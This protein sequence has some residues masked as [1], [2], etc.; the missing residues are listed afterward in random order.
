MVPRAPVATPPWVPRVSVLAGAGDDPARLSEPFGVSRGLDGTVYVTDAGSHHRIR[1]VSPRG[2]V[3]TLAGGIRGFADGTGAAARFD[4]PSGIALHPGGDLIV[5]DTANNAIRR[6]SPTG[7]VTTL[8]GDGVPGYRDGPAA[9]ARFNGPIGVAVDG[10][11]HVFVADTYNDRIREITP[12]GLTLTIAGDGTPGWLDGPALEARFDTPAGL[13]LD[14]SGTLVVADTGNG[15]IRLL[16][17][18]GRVTTMPAGDTRLARPVAVAA[19]A[20]GSVLASDEQ[21]RIF[22][23]S[24]EGTGRLLAGG[25]PGYEGGLGPSARFRRPAG[26]ALVGQRR[27]VL[28]DA[29]NGVLR[30]LTDP[31]RPD[32]RPPPSPLWRAAFDHDAFTRVPLLWPVPPF[33][34]PHEVAGTHGEARGAEGSERFHMGIDV[35]VPQGTA[36]HAVRPGVVSSSVGNGSVGTLNEWMRVGDIVYVHVRAGRERAGHV[37]DTRRYA[38][39]YDADGTL[40]R[41]R[42]KRGARFET[43]DRIGSVNAFNHVHLGVGWA[44]DDHNPLGMRLLHFTDTIP[45]TIAAGGVSLRREDGAPLTVRGAGRTLVSG[46]VEIVVDAWDQADGNVPWRRLGLHTLGYQVLSLDGTP[47]PGFEHPR[48]TLRFDRIGLAADPR[49]VYAAGS[50]IPAYGNRRTR[51]LYTVT[52]RLEEG[53]T[54]RDTWDTT[55]LPPGDYILRVHAADIA[56][57]VAV[58]RRDVPVT[59]LN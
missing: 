59:V 32:Q 52:N 5:A 55:Q 9:G 50:G 23:W 43:G 21:G 4:T 57:N 46:R 51:F 56:G 36:V 47:V 3:S 19:S 16:D 48:V 30:L 34:G 11:G 54:S 38:V 25:V 18:R 8:A 45:P 20:D 6:V 27:L 40:Q 26:L 28:A 42:V 12:Q 13:A 49:L 31:A 15:L 41:L 29:G 37:T 53:V 7:D 24:P 58:A 2:D 1:T 35:R 39:T 14:R 22:V 44:D 10:R 17:A 33:D